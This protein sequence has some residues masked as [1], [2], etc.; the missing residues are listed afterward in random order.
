MLEGALK[1]VGLA[2]A[3]GVGLGIGVLLHELGHAAAALLATRQRIEVALG[4]GVEE[5]RLASLSLGRLSIVLANWIIWIGATHYDRTKESRLVQSFVAVS[6]PL[7]SLIA[8]LA[9]VW[10]LVS[11]SL[12]SWLGVVA[13][14][15]LA[16]NFRI[17]IVAV[18]PI[19]YRPNG[20]D[21]EEWLSDAL[22]LWRLWRGKK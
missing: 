12:P 15:L 13:L 2:L 19:A 18:W 8:C 10:W 16:A 14:G 6:G 9:C 20:S 11:V 22:D 1:L 5:T 7:A 4:R 21:G 17:L 3:Y